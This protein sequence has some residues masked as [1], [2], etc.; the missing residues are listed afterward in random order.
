MLHTLWKQPIIKMKVKIRHEI[1][2][3]TIYIE[4][5]LGI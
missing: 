5:Q 2:P 1:N 3:R 4:F